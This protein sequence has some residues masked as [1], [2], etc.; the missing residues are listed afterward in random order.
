[1]SADAG[2]TAEGSPSAGGGGDKGGYAPPSSGTDAGGMAPPRKDTFAPEQESFLVREVATTDDYVFVPNSSS[3]STTVARISAG[4]LSVSPLEVGGR[5]V[6]VRAA[7][8]EQ[9]G[10]VAYVLTER[11]S[12]VAIVRA[13][14]VD[15]A[16]DRAHVSF[17][18]VPDEVN[19]LEMSP[20]GRRL[21]AYIDPDKPFADRT[22]AASLQVMSV[23]ELGETPEEDVAHE[24]SVSRLIRDV[25]FTEDGSEAYVVGREGINRLR[26][27]AID[28]DAL[29]PP[30]GLELDDSAYPPTDREVE[31]GPDG[32][33]LVVRS[34]AHAGV[35]LYRPSEDGGGTGPLR[36]LELP[37]PPTDIDLVE[38][39]GATSVVAAL[40]SAS[41]VAVI[42][43]EQA[44]NAKDP[45]VSLRFFEASGATPGLALTAP[46]RQNMLL[47]STL[48][49][50]PN[51]GRLDLQSGDLRAYS[52]R[53]QIRS[54]ALTSDGRTAIV[55]HDK[56]GGPPPTDADSVTFF[57]HHHGVTLVDLQSGYTRPVTLRARPEQF[58]V[59][60]DQ[61]G[62][63]DLYVILQSDDPRQRGLVQIDLSSY[64]TDF[65]RLPRQPTQLGRVG[66][67]IYVNQESE[68]GRITFVD[69]DTG[70]KQTISGY[71]LNARIE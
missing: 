29:V 49:S 19:A 22:S 23:V 31:V 59:T 21:L 9:T 25:E 71:E 14:G 45:T 58:V 6:A 52:L 33:I 67:R 57:R 42:D 35:A 43:V 69:V 60:E 64:R 56:Q 48:E 32:E 54:V 27:D 5:P 40:R 24:L 51:L 63:H 39:D 1:V 44:F 17:V 61:E 11:S 15:G 20:N 47:Y 8:L 66:D 34:S 28:G 68:Q 53:N 30:I 37:A 50:H 26:F 2:G 10:A 36:T 55:V 46:D 16:S 13:D 18:S 4:D 70:A 62:A 65:F 7:D 3:E 12:H 41:R 38:R